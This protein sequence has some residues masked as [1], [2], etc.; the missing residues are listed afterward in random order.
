MNVRVCRGSEGPTWDLWSFEEI[1]VEHRG[2]VVLLHM[3]LGNW[4]KVDGEL[5]KYKKRSHL[6]YSL[7]AVLSS[8]GANSLPSLF[9]RDWPCR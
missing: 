9:D 7:H 5:V 8:H 1:K 4:L 2:K 3:G 6:I